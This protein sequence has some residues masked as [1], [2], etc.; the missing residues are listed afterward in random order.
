M[1]GPSDLSALKELA[2]VP[3]HTAPADFLIVLPVAVSMLFGAGL[4]CLRKR[5]WLHPAVAI[6]LISVI[7]YWIDPLF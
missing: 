4:L 6:S 7:C 3:L 2:M 5:V 1:A